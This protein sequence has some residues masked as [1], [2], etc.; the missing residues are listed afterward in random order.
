MMTTNKQTLPFL[1]GEGE[2][3]Q[4]PLP[5]GE[6]GQRPGEGNTPLAPHLLTL[7]RKLRTE[8]TDA[9]PEQLY[10]SLHSFTPTS[11]TQFLRL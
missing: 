1:P 10:H 3:T 8:Q 7:A 5:L 2:E 4:L 6:G 9:V 11:L